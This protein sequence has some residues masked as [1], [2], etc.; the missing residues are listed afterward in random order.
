MTYETLA[1]FAQNWGTIFFI[2][3][4]WLIVCRDPMLARLLSLRLWGTAKHALQRTW[5]M[6]WPVAAT[7]GSEAGFFAVVALLVGTISASITG[8]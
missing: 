4:F 5:R 6:G 8:A 1:A 2:V 7:Y 3:A